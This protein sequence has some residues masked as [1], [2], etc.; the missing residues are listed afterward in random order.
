VDAVMHASWLD[1]L[2][3]TLA[4]TELAVGI[5]TAAAVAGRDIAVDE[6]ELRGATRRA[7]FVLAA[8]GDPERGL[9]LQGPAVTSFAAEIDTP[10]RRDA[11]EAGLARLAADAT[12][13]P[14]V[15]EAVRG[16][17]DAPETAWRAFACSV[18]AEH[19]DHD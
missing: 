9:D 4:Q 3:A 11:L 13:L 1:Q 18:L 5:V 6:E 17:L 19:I 2:E 10:E 8:G 15:S 12:G 7:V 14:H 16:L